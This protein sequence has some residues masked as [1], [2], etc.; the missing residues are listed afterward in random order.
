MAMDNVSSLDQL[1]VSPE[2]I[3]D[4]YPIYHR[5]REQDP[6]HWSEAWGCWVLTRYDDVV[7]ALRDHRR[8]TNV[9]RIAAFLD[10]LPDDVR[11]QDPPALR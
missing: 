4:P 5:L 8:F 1:L 7:T 2:I 6:V 11:A 9:G 3:S 10:Q